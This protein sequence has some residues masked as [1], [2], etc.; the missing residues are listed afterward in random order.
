MFKALVWSPRRPCGAPIDVRCAHGATIRRVQ[1]RI[2]SKQCLKSD[3]PLPVPHRDRERV[4]QRP[5]PA[6]RGKPLHREEALQSA[7]PARL[8]KV[9]KVRWPVFS[10]LTIGWAVL[11][12]AVR[13]VRRVTTMVRRG[14]PANL[15]PPNDFAPG[16]SAWADAIRAASIFLHVLTRSRPARRGE[17]GIAHTV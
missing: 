6:S 5:G 14:E 2:G 7:L 17:R 12:R 13:T 1:L 4:I 11:A 10:K 8:S 15:V 3:H 16:A 9:S